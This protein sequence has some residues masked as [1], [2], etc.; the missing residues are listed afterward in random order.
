M[1]DEIDITECMKYCYIE[2]EEDKNGELAIPTESTT[3]DFLRPTIRSIYKKMYCSL[4][5]YEG[6]YYQYIGRK[7]ELIDLLEDVTR[8]LFVNACKNSRT[9]NNDLEKKT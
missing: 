7:W 6:R 5:L 3:T 2:L 4:K 1:S 9:L 8:D